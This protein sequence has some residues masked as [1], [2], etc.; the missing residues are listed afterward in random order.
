MHAVSVA[1]ELLRQSITRRIFSPRQPDF[2]YL[3]MFIT[4]LCLTLPEFT[5][6]YKTRDVI[7]VLMRGSKQMEASPRGI[8]DVLDHPCHDGLRFCRAENDTTVNQDEVRVITFA[9]DGYQKA[10]AETLTIHPNFDS[11]FIARRAACYAGA[12]L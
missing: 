7:P 11:E 9:G 5:R 1:S 6:L 10:I 3:Q 12:S 4:L 8:D 2:I